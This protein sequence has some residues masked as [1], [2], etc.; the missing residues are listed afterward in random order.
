MILKKKRNYHETIY[1][2]PIDT[3]ETFRDSSTDMKGQLA[4]FLK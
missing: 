1:D 4:G 3:K 2:G